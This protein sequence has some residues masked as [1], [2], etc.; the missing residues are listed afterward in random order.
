MCFKTTWLWERGRKKAAMKARFRWVICCFPVSAVLT[1]E[2][3]E[4]SGS[5]AGVRV[6]VSE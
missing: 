4:S 2:G 1:R 5:F 6:S 3:D